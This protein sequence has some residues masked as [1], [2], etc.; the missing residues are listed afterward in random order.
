M[1][2]VR[3]GV[4]GSIIVL[5][6]FCGLTQT[7]A[8]AEVGFSLDIT[9]FGK[10]ANVGDNCG[11]T[12]TANS[13]V[14]L[15]NNYPN[16]YKDDNRIIR[17]AA[18][19]ITADASKTRDALG[20]GWGDKTGGRAGMGVNGTTLKP[21]WTTKVAW[22]EDW[23]PGKTRYAAQ[24]YNEPDAKNWVQGKNISSQYPTFTFMWDALNHGADIELNIINKGFTKAHALTL[25]GLTFGDANDNKK[26]DNGESLKMRFVDP[27]DPN[28]ANAGNTQP[29]ALSVGAD[30]RF[31]FTWWQD[32]DTWYIDS[33]LTETPVPAPAAPAL[34]GS[35]AGLLAFRRRRAVP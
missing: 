12:S 10:V 16:I 17:D 20:A 4:C 33:A 25:V 1:N 2:S 30:G 14:F 24:M 35:A 18:G 31:E 29:R 7:A 21:W 26:W 23:A 34:L 3:T 8:A 15:Q 28:Q 32:K 13:F 22:L 19:A 11:P 27:N 9:K 6:A 5:T